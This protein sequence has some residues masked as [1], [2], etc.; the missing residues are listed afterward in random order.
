MITSMPKW[1]WCICFLIVHFRVLFWAHLCWYAWLALMR[2]FLSVCLSLYQKSLD[3]NSWEKTVSSKS[4][5]CKYTSFVVQSPEAQNGLLVNVEHIR[6]M[7]ADYI[8]WEW[9]TVLLVP[10]KYMQKKQKTS[11]IYSTLTFDSPWTGLLASCK[12]ES[13]WQV[14]SFQRQVPSLE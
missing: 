11:D 4:A 5:S 6:R 14:C 3:N 10:Y 9:G 8:A 1:R 13:H 12:S 7:F 2:R